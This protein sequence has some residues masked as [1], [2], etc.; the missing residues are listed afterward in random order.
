[1]ADEVDTC[2]PADGIWAKIST[3][4]EV[5]PSPKTYGRVKAT[6][7]I[8]ARN[9]TNT[10]VHLAEPYHLPARNVFV[11]TAKTGSN[12]ELR[13]IA[14][15]NEICVRF[16]DRDRNIEP[17]ESFQ[18]TVEYE[19]MSEVYFDN[20]LAYDLYIVPQLAFQRIPVC[21]QQFR[22][23]LTL[24]TPEGERWWSLWLKRWRIQQRNSLKLS[25]TASNAN[26]A[27]TY[28]FDTFDVLDEPFNLKVSAVYSFRNWIAHAFELAVGA[29]A[30]VVIEHGLTWLE[31]L[32]LWLKGWWTA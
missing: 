10:C 30:I 17:G 21:K 8:T 22:I 26:K 25:P 13:A 31:K 1:M 32:A 28:N 15:N 3:N 7:T 23:S 24:F 11:V 27:A 18:W 29:V 14:S 16:D 19:R 6:V 4:I 5:R 12:E 9:T 20:I 2:P